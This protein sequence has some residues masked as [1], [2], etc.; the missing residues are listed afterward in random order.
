MALADPRVPSSSEAAHGPFPLVVVD[1]RDGND[2]VAGTYPGDDGPVPWTFDVPV[3]DWLGRVVVSG[4]SHTGV[5]ATLV[6][7]AGDG[8]A[9]RLEVDAFSCEAGAECRWSLRLLGRGDDWQQVWSYAA[10]TAFHPEGEASADLIGAATAWLIADAVRSAALVPPLAPPHHTPEPAPPP[11]VSSSGPIG[12]GVVAPSTPAPPAAAPGRSTY[13]D[14]DDR[15]YREGLRVLGN[16][17]DGD[18][19]DDKAGQ[20]ARTR[21]REALGDRLYVDPEGAWKDLRDYGP[22]GAALIADWLDSGARGARKKH[23]RDAA[24]WVLK[25]AP[26]DRVPSA[27]AWLDFDADPRRVFKMLRGRIPRFTPERAWWFVDHESARVR[28]DAAVAMVGG[29]KS[30]RSTGFR[31]FFIGISKGEFRNE[32][33]PPP[34]HHLDAVRAILART[35]DEGVWERVVK[36]IGALYSHKIP[37]QQAWREVLV[38]VLEKAPTDWEGLLQETALFLARGPCEGLPDVTDVV[39][40]TPV[41]DAHLLYVAGFEDRFEEEGVQECMIGPVETMAESGS[42]LSRLDAKKLLAKMKRQLDRESE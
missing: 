27:L 40:S 33:P 26:A 22:K 38:E 28:G 23:V 5:L 31:V 16:P 3:A 17:T 34:Q 10:S 15:G 39:L 29:D 9:F 41:P 21:R 1:A 32:V 42:G 13:A 14:F 8:P 25:C 4:L 2:R 18:C 19:E 30:H 6:D 37:G 11:I 36:S 7:D 24:Q 35:R 20:R 12:G